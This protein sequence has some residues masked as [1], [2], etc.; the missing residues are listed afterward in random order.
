MKGT[1]SEIKA[2]RSNFHSDI[3][4]LFDLRDLSIF[5]ILTVSKI[6]NNF[7]TNSVLK[8]AP[9]FRD[10]DSWNLRRLNNDIIRC[11]EMTSYVRLFEMGALLE[12]TEKNEP[13]LCD[14]KISIVQKK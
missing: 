10:F 3:T 11:S 6:A 2:T 8:G 4:A 14:H 9:N 5:N 12:A 7:G 1:E 13:S